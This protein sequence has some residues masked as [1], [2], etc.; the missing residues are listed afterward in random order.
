MEYISEIAKR[1]LPALEEYEKG[2]QMV[3][4]EFERQFPAIKHYLEGQKQMLPA[5]AKEFLHWYFVVRHEDLTLRDLRENWPGIVPNDFK[6][7]HEYKALLFEHGGK[8]GDMVHQKDDLTSIPTSFAELFKRPESI[9]VAIRA[10]ENVGLVEQISHRQWQW[11]SEKTTGAIRA[12]FE[13]LQDTPG[14]IHKIKLTPGCKLI[15]KEFGVVEVKNYPSANYTP[16][17]R[18]KIKAH[19]PKNRDDSREGI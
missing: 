12:F 14:M 7:F 10:V 6:L 5:D 18:K 13:A 15:A 19:L 2:K 16:G 4:D 3:V 17:L 11:I 9:E 8:I 1:I